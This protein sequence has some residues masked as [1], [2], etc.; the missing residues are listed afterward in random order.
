[1]LVVSGQELQV[2]RQV[3]WMQ[4]DVVADDPRDCH[5]DADD[6]GA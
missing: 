3:H 4:L 6:D 5:D 1:M 2:Q